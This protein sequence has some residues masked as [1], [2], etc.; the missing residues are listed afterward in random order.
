MKTMKR[1]ILFIICLAIFSMQIKAQLSYNKELNT[2]NYDN[3]NLKDQASQQPKD[4]GITMK[5]KFYFCL[6][7]SIE[8]SNY[9]FNDQSMNVLSTDKNYGFHFG[10]KLQYNFTEKFS[11]RTGFIYSEYYLYTTAS[12]KNSVIWDPGP[13][14]TTI[15]KIKP[16]FNYANIPLFVGYTIF[17]KGRFKLTPSAGFIFSNGKENVFSSQL[18][19]GCEYFIK[20]N[21]FITIEPF[22]N[23]RLTPDA[24]G[25]ITYKDYK[26]SF[27]GIFS[28]NYHF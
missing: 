8:K 27:G 9:I 28:I 13:P 4:E 25:Y 21:F 22:F 18:N 14:D 11:I 16:K 26:T 3:A 5:H 19:L 10:L 23:Y 12:Y 17:S 15:C 6:M 20:N 7:T 1:K 24:E 2:I